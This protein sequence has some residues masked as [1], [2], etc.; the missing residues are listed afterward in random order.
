MALPE[1]LSTF[2]GR[3]LA[4][5]NTNKALS[6]DVAKGIV[7][8]TERYAFAYS[9]PATQGLK[10]AEAIVGATRALAMVAKYRRAPNGSRRLGQSFA[11]ISGHDGVGQRLSLLVDLDVE[12]AAQVLDGLV[13]RVDDVGAAINFY[14]LVELLTFWDTGDIERDSRHRAQLSYDFYR[15]TPALISSSTDAPITKD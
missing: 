9:V 3:L 12:Q 10:R 8:E 1:E 6:S 2:I 14:A 7:A 15:T 11:G 5:R 13:G 4:V